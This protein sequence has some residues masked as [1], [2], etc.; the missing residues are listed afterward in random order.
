MT[1]TYKGNNMQ[2]T[3]DGTSWSIGNTPQ[4][5]IDI[6]SFSSSDETFPY[7]PP[8]ATTPELETP[9][10]DPCPPGYIYDETLKQCKV[11]AKEKQICVGDEPSFLY[12]RSE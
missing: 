1:E 5:F 7:V 12:V 10:T 4:N 3:Y 2:L 6:N 9:E 8:E 11:I